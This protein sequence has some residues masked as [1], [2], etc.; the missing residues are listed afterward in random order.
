MSIYQPLLELIFDKNP[1][2]AKKCLNDICKSIMRQS[3][4]NPNVYNITYDMI[5]TDF[6]NPIALLCRG[7]FIEYKEQNKNGNKEQNKDGNKEQNKDENR[8]EILCCAF[9]KFFNYGEKEYQPFDE[10]TMIV[11]EKWDGSLI[12]LYYYNDNWQIGTNNCPFAIDAPCDMEKTFHD[13]F[14]ESAFQNNNINENINEN[15]ND[16]NNVE[17]KLEDLEWVKLLDREFCYVFEMIHP[18]SQVVVP[19]NTKKIIHLLTR[20]VKTGREINFDTETDTN[21]TLPMIEKPKR[22]PYKSIQQCYDNI[23]LHNEGV[24]IRDINNQRYKIKSPEYVEDH[25]IADKKNRER[26]DVFSIVRVLER[27]GASNL[28]D[29]KGLIYNKPNMLELV[30]KTEQDFK[31]LVTIV[32]S[33]IQKYPTKN[34]FIKDYF[35]KNPIK[36]GSKTN[37]VTFNLLVNCYKKEDI[38]SL[39]LKYCIATETIPSITPLN[40]NQ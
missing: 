1:E 5:H 14:L 25:K 39:V 26:N 27:I 20:H 33:Y 22:Y 37:D 28:D 19:Y 40:I 29:Y 3:R 21:L 18:E 15:N 38:C 17:N 10:S 23:L 8:W 13:L 16:K 30:N 34:D 32:E 36:K 2:E 7:L 12:K 24:V 4:S 6:N 9:P 11:E 31:K 35:N